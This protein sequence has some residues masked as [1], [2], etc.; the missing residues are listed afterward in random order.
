MVNV[1]FEQSGVDTFIQLAD[2]LED[3]FPTVMVQETEDGEEPRDGSFEVSH[4][5]GTVLFSKLASGRMPRLEEVLEA[6]EN[7]M[8]ADGVNPFASP[9]G[10][11]AC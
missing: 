5:D 11:G 6:L 4:E 10:G 8:K 2:I 7:K 9:K 3:A 1:E